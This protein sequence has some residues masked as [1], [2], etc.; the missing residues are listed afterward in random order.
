M[1][2]IYPSPVE[3]KRRREIMAAAL[4]RARASRL[5][6][7]ATRAAAV[8]AVQPAATLKTA[9]PAGKR[10]A[11]RVRA[12]VRADNSHDDAAC[13]ASKSKVATWIRE[14]GDTN[15]MTVVS[16]DEFNPGGQRVWVIRCGACDTVLRITGAGGL[17]KHAACAAHVAALD[18]EAPESKVTMWIREHGD[19][20]KMTVVSNDE[21]NTGGGRVWLIR[22]GACDTG[23]RVTAAGALQRHA[24]C[25]PHVAALDSGRAPES[26]VATWI[27]EHGD[28]NKMTVVSKETD[29]GGKRTWVV[30]C[31]ACDTVIRARG[32]SDLKSHASTALHAAALASGTAESNVATW[33]RKHGDANKMTVVSNDEINTGGT[34]VWVVRCGACDT[35]IRANGAGTLQKHAACAPHTAALQSGD[36]RESKVAAWLREH[37]D[38]NKMTVV[39]IDE[40]YSNGTRV[41]VIRCGACDTVTRAVDAGRLQKHA[42][43]A[44]HAAALQCGD[45]RESCGSASRKRCRS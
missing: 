24:A 32:A 15:K 30:R 31:G 2:R 14:H 17:Q 8:A 38:A 43:C 18:G 26:N 21:I 35:A 16:N 20:N 13:R 40:R 29:A 34:R 11:P 10:G 25:A 1:T 45:A 19:A 22:C 23:I 39:S 41:W 42:A 33:I 9:A 37:G 5:A 36:A 3:Q 4:V 6:A 28:S 27:R 44:Q 7:E 12:E